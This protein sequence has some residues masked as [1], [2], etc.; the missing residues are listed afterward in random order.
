MMEFLVVI[1]PAEEGGYWAEILDVEGCFV[2]GE[3]IEK[4]LAD[5][6]LAIAAHIEAL[7]A[8]GQPL[9]QPRGVVLATVAAPVPST[10]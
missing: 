8:D 7:R 1:H 10:A 9:P 2:Q 5:A 4:L 3:T 6:P